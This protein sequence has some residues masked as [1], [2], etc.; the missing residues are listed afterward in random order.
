MKKILLCPFLFI[1]FYFLIGN[2]SEATL[3]DLLTTELKESEEFKEYSDD[4]D[5]SA[6]VYSEIYDETTSCF[7]P[8]EA[9]F[10]LKNLR[11]QKLD[12]DHY[13]ISWESGANNP[14]I[15]YHVFASN[16]WQDLMPLSFPKI[17]IESP[18]A[19]A[20]LL[21]STQDTSVQVDTFRHYRI[22]AQYQD[23]FVDLTRLTSLDDIQIEEEE[24]TRLSPFK[25]SSKKLAY[26]P[27]IS[28]DIWQQVT[29]YLIPS[30]HFAKSILDK[31]FFDSKFR[32][33]T[34][35]NGLKKAGFEILH[36][37]QGRGLIIARHPL[38]RKHLIKIYLDSAPRSEW[39]AWVLR[40]KGANHLQKLIDHYGYSHY[41]KVPQKWIYPIPR[42]PKQIIRGQFPKNFLLV[43]QDMEI[44]GVKSNAA[45]YVAM[46][47]PFVEAL[48][49]IIFK[50]GLSDAHIANVP[51]SID[52]KI[53][54][55]DTEFVN[56]WPVHW[57]WLTPFLSDPMKEIWNMLS[58]K[59]APNNV[60]P[61]KN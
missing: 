48:H 52:G 42:N 33:L 13:E 29:P 18:L 12:K 24:A 16:A 60:K 41:M 38:L 30:N 49:H 58:T 8:K 36:H 1:I 7:L 51:F 53:A 44:L 4:S 9:L 39:S 19:K 17:F 45:K 54:F 59:E 15:I 10:K 35:V 25:H 11:F 21:L 14:N 28:E 34:S 43:V 32:I 5:S 61:E 27:S 2:N 3:S 50:G 26:S 47:Q 37:R 22:I 46:S 23:I 40:S 31:I 57:E 55:I 6:S 56:N 20:Y